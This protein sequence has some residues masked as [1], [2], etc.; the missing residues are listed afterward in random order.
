MLSLGA[1]A[2]AANSIRFEGSVT[3]VDRFTFGDGCG[4]VHGVWDGTF[5]PDNGRASALHVDECTEPTGTGDLHLVGDF[6]IVGASGSILGTITTSGP[7]GTGDYD[8]SITSGTRRYRGA[9]G[10]L[11]LS[12]TWDTST[13]GAFV[14]E[15]TLR[16]TISR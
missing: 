1:P 6:S 10:A 7:F 8:V 12:G 3:L 2:G 14:F 15:G 11:R 13:F 5:V 9:S 4:F 16:G